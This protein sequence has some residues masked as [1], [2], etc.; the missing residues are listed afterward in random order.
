MSN[1]KNDTVRRL[2][3]S[4][5]F[6]GGEAKEH[7]YPEWRWKYYAVYHTDECWFSDDE[8][9]RQGHNF[10]CVSKRGKKRRAW[11]HRHNTESEALT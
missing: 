3:V 1:A 2:V 11:D 6:C 9:I 10:T 7:P 4:C 5:P 8:F